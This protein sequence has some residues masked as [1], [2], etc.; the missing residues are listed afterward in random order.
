MS[1][2][3]FY[4]FP[5]AQSP[6]PAARTV[7]ERLA[8]VEQ[9]PEP[10][11]STT[12][13]RYKAVM[14]TGEIVTDFHTGRTR[15]AHQLDRSGTIH[16]D[17]MNS[18][19]A[20]VVDNHSMWGTGGE[21]VLGIVE[22]GTVSMAAEGLVGTIQFLPDDQLPPGIRNG[23]A[24]GVLQN[25]S[26]QVTV[27]GME[28]IETDG[29]VLAKITEYDPFEISVVPVG[30]D[31]GAKL[32]RIAQSIHGFTPPS[33]Q[34][35]HGDRGGG[36]PTPPNNP[37]PTPEGQ[38]TVDGDSIRA[39]ERARV[40][41]IQSIC[42]AV[43]LDPQPWIDSGQSVDDVRQAIRQRFTGA[44]DLF[45]PLVAPGESTIAQHFQGG[46]PGAPL[47]L[48]SP[49]SPDEQAIVRTE[50]DRIAAIRQICQSPIASHADP[51]PFID[52]GQTADQV[53]AE[54]WNQNSGGDG[55]QRP[56]PDNLDAGGDAPSFS[57]AS[58]PQ[59]GS[60]EEKM[61]VGIQHAFLERGDPDGIVATH[62]K[63]TI[64]A[65]EY[66]GISL[67]DAGRMLIGPAGRDIG[68]G[69]EA[70][71]QSILRH[72][73]AFR[74]AIGIPGGLDAMASSSAVLGAQGSIRQSFGGIGGDLLGAQ[75]RSDLSVVIEN[76]MHRTM[77]AAFAMQGE[78]S[79]WRACCTVKMANDFRP[80]N[81]IFLG[82]LPDFGTREDTGDFPRAQIPNP[83]K[84]T[85]QV[86]E[87]GQT[88]VITRTTIID[89]DL[90]VVFQ[91]PRLQGMGAQRLINHMFFQKLLL[92]GGLGPNVDV[93]GTSRSLF[94]ADHDNLGAGLA[95]DAAAVNADR[96]LMARQSM[97]GSDAAKD[98]SVGGFDLFAD[99]R[100]DTYLIPLEL[101]STLMIIR[102]SE[103]EPGTDNQ[104]TQKGTFKT[105]VSTPLL[106]G[107]RRYGFST[108]AMGGMNQSP[109]CVSFFGQQAPYM[110]MAEISVGRGMVWHAAIDVGV[111]A[112][113]YR[114]A[115]TNA[116]V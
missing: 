65:G 114:G 38:Q 60:Q 105:I 21:S 13:R 108:G 36:G 87:R 82:A 23:L 73:E 52:G 7:C 67:A 112:V 14:M 54:L 28:R 111:D 90:G 18:G 109:F 48:S 71:A 39:A 5:L 32:M 77:S 107:T 88:I 92:N 95:L 25:L 70:V 116:G 115:V 83:E 43:A 102:D 49:N 93:S 76:L 80:Q 35:D 37:Q 31:S 113:N 30:A 68:F 41:E 57:Q 42:Q 12:G 4:P 34:L 89:D 84:A 104:N 101:E 106:T 10:G 75:G 64:N 40:L 94:H 22:K 99:C 44:G 97:V 11:D 79:S 86:T 103:K 61:I 16:L 8:S 50:R 78:V 72:S 9:A 56:T 46:L 81:H 85:T 26:V 59:G 62:E 74:Q 33:P 29:L 98:Q 55:G 63:L 100:L 96:V 47:H 110:F 27:L 51:Q 45:R 20:P 66:R 17:R 53:R 69:R 2:R 15:F 24:S 19:R 58:T 91:T 6:D 1:P 3:P